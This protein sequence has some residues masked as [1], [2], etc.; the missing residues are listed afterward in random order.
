[1]KTNLPKQSYEIPAC[2]LIVI[3]TLSLLCQ[4]NLESLSTEKFEEQIIDGFSF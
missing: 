3:D 4:S 1:M 2:N